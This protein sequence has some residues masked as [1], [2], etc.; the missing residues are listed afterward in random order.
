MDIPAP[1]TK[2][3]SQCKLPKPID[4][5]VHFFRKNTGAEARKAECNECR[6]KKRRV[7]YA[8][9]PE[10]IREANKR[11]WKKNS[12]RYTV[13]RVVQR[14]EASEQIRESRK[15]PHRRARH[16]ELS[17]LKRINN[18]EKVRKAERDRYQRNPE[19]KKKS[20]KKWYRGHREQSLA[21]HNIWRLNNPILERFHQRKSKQQ[22]LARLANT[23]FVEYV[24]LDILCIRDNWRCHVCRK[25]VK[26][27]D[28][29]R[30]HIVP[31]SKQGEMSYINILLAHSWCNSSR[32]AGRL[33][34]QFL[35]FGLPP[36]LMPASKDKPINQ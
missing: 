26:R 29:S 5:F 28:A 30:D 32:G 6:N 11:G 34:A 14:A 12:A 7:D 25:R 24:D 31:A 13:R 8:K 2:V 20:A 36:D 35:L 17:R 9:N 18:P 15:Q 33:P 4:Q 23:R 19:P 1:K 16:N 22:Y 27:E 3:C 21:T 10:P